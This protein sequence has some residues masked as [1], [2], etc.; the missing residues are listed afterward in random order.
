MA[1]LWNLKLSSGTGSLP[2]LFP[3]SNGNPGTIS[4]DDPRYFHSLY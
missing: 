3:G 2:I 4:T 1:N